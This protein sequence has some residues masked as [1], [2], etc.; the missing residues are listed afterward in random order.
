MKKCWEFMHCGRE[1]GGSTSESK[2]VCPVATETILDGIN[3][4][5]NGGRVCW[6]VAGAPL[7]AEDLG[8]AFALD[9]L[10]VSC[11]FLALVMREEGRRF[12]LSSKAAA[13]LGRIDPK[14]CGRSDSDVIECP[15]SKGC[16]FFSN[17]TGYSAEMGDLLRIRYCYGEPQ[18]CARYIGRLLFGQGEIPDD[19]L[20]ADFH[21]LERFILDRCAAPDS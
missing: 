19:M 20:P 9:T 12:V 14:G 2:G 4:G 13:S 15:S 18:S 7:S 1:P 8:G 10:C 3:D 21:T 11:P 17:P 16:P 5:V 6:V